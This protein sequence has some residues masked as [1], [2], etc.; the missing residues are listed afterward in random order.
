MGFPNLT[1]IEIIK[2]TPHMRNISITRACQQQE[3]TEK[4]KNSKNNLKQTTIKLHYMN[5][6][7]KNSFIKFITPITKTRITKLKIC[8]STIYKVIEK[9]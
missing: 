8:F 7:L 6:S 4:C 9:Y 5:Q 2:V 3:Y 1:A